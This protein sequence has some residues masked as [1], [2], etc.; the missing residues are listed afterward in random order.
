MSADESMGMTWWNGMSRLER[1]AVLGQAEAVLGHAP[2]AADC[3]S[4]WKAG[5]VSMGRAA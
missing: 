1:S 2:S 4:L 5:R 3:W